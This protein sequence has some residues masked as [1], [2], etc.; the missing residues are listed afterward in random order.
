M[1]STRQDV[2]RPSDA[3]AVA[4]RYLRRERPLSALVALIVVAIFVGTFLATSLVPALVIGAALVLL[5]RAPIIRSRGSVRLQ[6]D[7]DVESVVDS[8]TGATPPVLAFQWGIADRISTEDGRVRYHISY[9]FGLRSVAVTVETETEIA[10]NGTQHVELTVTANERPWS[11][12]AVRISRTADRT[13]IEYEYE[14][15]RRFGLRRIPQRLVA[16]RYRDEALSAQGY[17]V[18]DR[19]EHFGV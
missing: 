6:T 18:V 5:T 7:A 11:T 14:A 8:F 13:V 17:T 19:D 2:D 15:D 9:L 3:V 4:N 16:V 12:Y 10:A 1:P